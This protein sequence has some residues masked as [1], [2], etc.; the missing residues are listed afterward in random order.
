MILGTLVINYDG[1]GE[2]SVSIEYG[3]NFLNVPLTDR[4]DILDDVSELVSNEL[5]DASSALEDENEAE[6]EEISEEEVDD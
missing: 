3:A 5:W 4:V 1:N 6:E 2:Y